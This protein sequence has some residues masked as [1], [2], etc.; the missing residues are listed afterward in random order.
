MEWNV[1]QGQRP[2]LWV[3]AHFHEN[4]SRRLYDTLFLVLTTMY[5]RFEYLGLWKGMSMEMYGRSR[6]ILE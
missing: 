6:K 3:T 4:F 1:I 2:I 5:R